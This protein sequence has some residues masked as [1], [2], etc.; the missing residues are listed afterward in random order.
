MFKQQNELND[1][2]NE[3]KDKIPNKYDI[4]CSVDWK[5]YD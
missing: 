5:S 4:L 3:L 1:F 2:L